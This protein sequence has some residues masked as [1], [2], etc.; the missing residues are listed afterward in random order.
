M[1]KIPR[2]RLGHKK[3]DYPYR[4]SGRISPHVCETQPCTNIEVEPSTG[5]RQDNILRAVVTVQDTT[6]LA[7]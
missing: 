4:K 3:Q 2:D 7:I 5:L 6:C 1:H